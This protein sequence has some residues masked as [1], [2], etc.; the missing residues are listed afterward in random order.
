MFRA[1]TL[2]LALGAALA[3]AAGGCSDFLTDS[4]ATKD[5]NQ[6]TSASR[7]QLFVAVQA[8]QFGIQESGVAEAACMF[9][10]GCAGVGGR[11]V[12]ER[13][14]Y[15][16]TNSDFS[17]DFTQSYA[18]G[19]LVDIRQV[20]DTSRVRGDSVYLGIAKVW[21]A[22]DIG[23]AADVW[24]DVPYREAA[25]PIGHPTPSLDPQLQVY[26]DLQ[27][28]LNEAIREIGSGTG[29]GPEAVDLVYGAGGAQK[30]VPAAY[31][32]KAR[33]FMHTA[34]VRGAA[35]YDSAIAAALHGITTP[36]NDW[37]ALHTTATSERN[38]WFQFST[39]GF[40][41]DIVAGKLL[42]DLMNAR[43]DP[44]LPDYFGQAPD[45]GFGGEDQPTGTP[46]PNGASPLNG[47]RNDPTFR[48]PL[49]TYL[50][51]EL[52]LAEAY[53]KRGQDGPALVHLNN[54]RAAVRHADDSP[55]PLPAL[56]GLTGN[57][58]FQAIVAEKYIAEFQNI[59]AWNDYKR[60]CYAGLNLH[61][62]VGDGVVSGEV[63]GRLFY[64]QTEENANSNI[65][66]ANAQ[67]TN[68]GVRVGG[69]SVGGF[70]NPNDPN[71]CP[72]V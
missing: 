49:V 48:Q 43:N 1:R 8:A 59:E 72:A 2:N 61:P 66:D 63:P 57:A 60:T 4:K 54:A 20:Q 51:N 6:A 64:G 39:T 30:W 11:F 44:R 38:I 27:R 33:L 13:A 55:A 36:S 15:T 16:F 17:G 18:G 9:T 5:P 50:E 45:G 69:P 23:T 22:L 37:R 52:I 62:V 67:L 21:E 71:P 14:G 46:S 28:V 58:L 65:P 53:Q 42:V 7:N 25:D 10:Q 26:D 12:E 35:A 31:T 68:G 24:G 41:N 19:G 32:L 29:Q 47:A 40:G 34:E 3:V 70:R 56:V